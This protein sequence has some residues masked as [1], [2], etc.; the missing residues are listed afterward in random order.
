MLSFRVLY[1]LLFPF[2]LTYHKNKIVLKKKMIVLQVIAI[3]FI[4]KTLGSTN[5]KHNIYT[6]DNRNVCNIQGEQI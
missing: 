5:F 6:I 1:Y 3:N 4:L 2:V